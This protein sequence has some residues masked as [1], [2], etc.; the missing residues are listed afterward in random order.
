M[1]AGEYPRCNAYVTPM[2]VG[3]YPR[4][5]AY[6][7]SITTAYCVDLAFNEFDCCLKESNDLRS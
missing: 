2:N 5:N 1:N 4:C 3:E 7:C 6:V